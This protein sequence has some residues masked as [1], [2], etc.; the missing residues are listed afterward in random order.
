[1]IKVKEGDI[2]TLKRCITNVK[3]I[4]LEKGDR[5][6][7]NKVWG[8]APSMNPI[9][10]NLRMSFSMRLTSMPFLYFWDYFE[11]KQ[12]RRKRIIKD[13]LEDV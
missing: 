3:G 4:N 9:S 6:I 13:I 1:M 2:Y 5:M 11:T 7:C 12:E 10:S 8:E